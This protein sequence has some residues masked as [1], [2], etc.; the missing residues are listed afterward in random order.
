[1]K[2]NDQTIEG[3]GALVE[4]ATQ[5][6]K[7]LFGPSA[8]YGLHM[9]PG[10]YDPDEMVTLQENVEL[11]KA[12]SESEIKETVFSMEK[13]L[14]LDLIISPLNFINIVGILSRRIWL[15]SF[16]TFII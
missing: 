9:E 12:F 2:H 5:Y 4:H 1:M 3:D 13:T 16:L 10:C 15:L 6:Y 8:P 14:L 11:Q 7:E